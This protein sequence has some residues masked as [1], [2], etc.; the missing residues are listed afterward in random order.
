MQKEPEIPLH[1]MPSETQTQ[2]P[3]GPVPEPSIHSDVPDQS[4]GLYNPFNSYTLPNSQTSDISS[5]WSRWSPSTKHED[6][7]HNDDGVSG[8]ISL[9]NNRQRRITWP[10]PWSLFK[11]STA[12]LLASRGVTEISTQTNIWRCIWRLRIVY[13]FLILSFWFR[14]SSHGSEVRPSVAGH[15]GRLGVGNSNCTTW[16]SCRTTRPPITG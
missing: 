4:V 2:P 16:R 13:F 1:S 7:D 10:F 3:S 8:D 11:L 5:H 9:T 6:G 12:I 14:E 15:G